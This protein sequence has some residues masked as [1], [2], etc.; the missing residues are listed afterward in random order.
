MEFTAAVQGAKTFCVQAGFTLL[1]LQVAE[2]HRAVRRHMDLASDAS[3]AT[4][5]AAEPPGIKQDSCTQD[6]DPRSVL[7]SSLGNGSRSGSGSGPSNMT[8]NAGNRAASVQC[9]QSL[10]QTDVAAPQQSQLAAPVDAGANLTETA[11]VAAI[12]SCLQQFRKCATAQQQVQ[13]MSPTAGGVPLGVREGSLQEP[14]RGTFSAANSLP[15]EHG[16]GY[17]GA[18]YMHQRS[19]SHPG[20]FIAP[21][22]DDAALGPCGGSLPTA[23]SGWVDE[24]RALHAAQGYGISGYSSDPAS[25]GPGLNAR[26]QWQQQEQLMAQQHQ[27]QALAQ[28]QQH[29]HQQQALAQQQ[30]HEQQALAQQQ[31]QQQTNSQIG[32]QAAQNMGY[33]P[34]SCQAQGPQAAQTHPTAEQQSGNGLDPVLL[35]MPT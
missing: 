32:I 24:Q 28:H 33:Y 16:Y 6:A 35:H 15:L 4:A 18:A 14:N 17:D 9:S 3:E 23:M 30:Q 2:L 12:A 27:H 7:L 29:Q 1:G 19:H 25:Q 26:F 8:T 20:A 10:D 21:Q 22:R 31:H 11:R 13:P 5:I 34:G